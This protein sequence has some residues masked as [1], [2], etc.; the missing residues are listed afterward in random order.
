MWILGGVFERF[1]RLQVVFVEPGVG[2]IPWWL[3]LVDD[4]V[5]RQGY[6]YPDITEL[7]S[8]YFHRNV[9]ITFIDE[10]EALGFDPF[11]YRIGVENILWSTDYPHP[12]SSYPNSR[13]VAAACV[14][15]LPVGEGE[16]ILSGNAKRIWKI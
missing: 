7:P 8:H 14:D 1:P 16:A 15:G 4:M 12:V 9:A 2:W 11:R 5:I 6:S 10:A 3:N 13:N